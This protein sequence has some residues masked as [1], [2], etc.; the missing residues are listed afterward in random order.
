MADA[1]VVTERLLLRP[2][3]QA[4]ADALFPIFS[5]PRIW[6]FEPDGV[7][8]DVAQTAAY[9]ASAGSRWAVDGLSYWTLRLRETGEVVGS[10]GA[11][12]HGRGEW[13]LNYRVAVERQGRGYAGEMLR[14][15]LAATA[16][17]DPSAPCVASIDAVNTPSISVAL[18]A[19]LSYAGDR[20]SSFDGRVRRYY[21]DRPLDDALFPPEQASS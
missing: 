1:E 13:N 19:G 14:A 7:H 10:G 5:D 6:W 17:V 3:V 16:A 15:A 20:R 2:M 8:T 18:D 9:A 4:D 21:A 11:Q 12:R